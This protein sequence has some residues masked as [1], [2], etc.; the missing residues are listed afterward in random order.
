M[1]IL[2]FLLMLLAVLPGITYA[3]K[4][5]DFY[6][7]KCTVQAGYAK[8]FATL[9]DKGAKF[10][11]ALDMIKE[12]GRYPESYHG[13]LIQILQDTYTLTSASPE[14]IYISA[15]NSCSNRGNFQEKTP[16]FGRGNARDTISNNQLNLCKQ[17]ADELNSDRDMLTN[18]ERRL[19]SETNRL[20]NEEAN[21]GREKLAIQGGIQMDQL[22]QRIRSH[23]AA[24]KDFLELRQ[25]YELIANRFN[26]RTNKFNI[27]CGG[28]GVR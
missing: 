12:K 1:N 15:L 13:P 17:L 23:N 16:L 18:Y 6:S 10:T 2:K 4:E 24:V 3:Q 25:S 8:Q 5:T 27:E 7:Q 26:S 20:E 19:D 9:R 22:N 28:K 14:Q 21:I 11:Q